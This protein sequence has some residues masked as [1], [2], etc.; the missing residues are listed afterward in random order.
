VGYTIATGYGRVIVPFADETI[1]ELSCHARGAQWLF[2][3]ARTILDMGGQDCKA[4]RCDGRGILVNF[5]M[6]DKCAAG[7]G[8]FL[9]LIAEVMGLPISQ[10]GPLSLQADGEAPIN[11]TCA[12][13]AKSEVAGLI[14][15]GADRRQILAGLNTA[16]ASRIY[17]LLRKVG[18]EKD[19]VISGG[20]AKNPGIVKNVEER[21]G[22][23][24]LLPEEPQ[25][26]GALGAALFAQDKLARLKEVRP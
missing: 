11:N 24:A 8:R 5:A 23:K 17:T 20:I 26:V 19:L 15:K 3:S 6:N 4:I 13:F 1:T 14:S 16:L 7:T 18:I 22:L 21:V 2:P 25:I 10:L 12:V 9:E